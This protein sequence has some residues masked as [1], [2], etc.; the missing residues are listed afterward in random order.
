M[1]IVMERRYLP[2]KCRRFLGCMP[3]SRQDSLVIKNVNY[4]HTIPEVL[5]GFVGYGVVHQLKTYLG[6]GAC[7]Q[8]PPQPEPIM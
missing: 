2:L 8:I 3:L 1:P 7:G 6:N 4:L 5:N